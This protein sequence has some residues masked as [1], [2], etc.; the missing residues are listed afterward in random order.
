MPRTTQRLSEDDRA[1]RLLKR[2]SA[3]EVV[4]KINVSQISS[5]DL[6]LILIMLAPDAEDESISK[7]RWEK[8][9]QQWRKKVRAAKSPAP[10]DVLLSKFCPLP[11]D[12][13]QAK[14]LSKT[15]S[16]QC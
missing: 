16:W 6:R 13:D 12:G 14:R 2:R 3:L 10:E 15:R 1:R 4:T 9:V 5:G 11:S 7:R 8:A